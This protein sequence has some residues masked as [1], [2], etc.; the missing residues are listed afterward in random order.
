MT[1]P[2]PQL[3][4]IDFDGVLADISDTRRNQHLARMLGCVTE[5]VSAALAGIARDRRQS[6]APAHLDDLQALCATLEQRLQ[7]PVPV[8]TWVQARMA[9]TTLRRDCQALLVQV[10]RTTPIAV[11]TN[12]PTELARPIE[13]LLDI[14]AIAGRVLTSGALGLRKPD[15]ACYL[16]AC[17][18]LGAEPARTLFIDNLFANAQGARSAGLMADTAH[19]AQSLR[20]VLK[21]F[22][23]LR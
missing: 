23:L 8:T 20:K 4:L 16:A 2:V 1:H 21:R 17:R 14:P 3:L 5:T 7:I 22:H 12:N 11:L 6:E 13:T 10:A 9:A 18:Q 19:H 15:P